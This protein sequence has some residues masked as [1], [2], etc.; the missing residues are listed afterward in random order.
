[1]KNKIAVYEWND[2]VKLRFMHCICYHSS[3]N[4]VAKSYNYVCYGNERAHI[5]IAS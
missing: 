2:I 3:V 1:M 5:N 4:T